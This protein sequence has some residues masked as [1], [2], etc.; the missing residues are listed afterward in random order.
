[1]YRHY[2]SIRFHNLSIILYELTKSPQIYKYHSVS[3]ITVRP[4]RYRPDANENTLRQN[5]LLLA[6]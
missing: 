6:I 4:Y 3:T 2:H 5:S 1:M